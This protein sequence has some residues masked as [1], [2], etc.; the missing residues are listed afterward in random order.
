MTKPN[1]IVSGSTSSNTG[2]RNL[3]DY[4]KNLTWGAPALGDVLTGFDAVN[5]VTIHF[6]GN[7]PFPGDPAVVTGIVIA[8]PAAFPNP[9]T[10]IF[11]LNGFVTT[12]PPFG[13]QLLAQN[14]KFQIDQYQ[15]TSNPQGLDFL[16][17]Q[18]GG[19][20]AVGYSIFGGAGADNFFGS[21][22]DDTLTGNGG[23]DTLTG[24]AGDD[25]Y[26]VGDSN[27]V[28]VEQSGQGHD[29]VHA[30][31]NYTL[32]ANMEDL[33]LD[34]GALGAGNNGSNAITANDS[35]NTLTG[36]A[37]SDK[38]I[39]L[40]GNDSLDGGAGADCLDG[41]SGVDTMAGGTEN[42]TYVVDDSNDIIIEAALTKSID[43]VFS[44][45]NYTLSA[46]VENMTLT[47]GREHDIN[48]MGN[49]LANV[50][51]GNIADN[52]I[53]GLEGNDTLIGNKGHDTLIGG[54]ENDTYVV[55]DLLVK[56]VEL[57]NQGTDIVQ[58]SVN[59]TLPGNV[60]NLALT[61]LIGH[62]GGGNTQDNNITGTPGSDNIDGNIGADTMAGGA[63]DDVYRVNELGDLVVELSG[64]GEDFVFSS[65]DYT[66]PGNVD[67]LELLEGSAAL[68][69]IGNKLANTIIGNSGGKTLDGAVGADTM[70]GGDGD[71]LYFADN[72]S[73]QANEG[74]QAGGD[75]VIS[76][77]SYTLSA[78]VE[79]L[80]LTGVAGLHGGGNDLDNHITGNDGSNIINGDTGA[81]TMTGGLGGDTYIVDDVGD[82]VVEDANPG[83]DKI[84]TTKSYTLPGNVERL[85]LIGG[86]T[87]N[88]GKGN[89]DANLLVGNGFAN[90][91][92]G[93]GGADT[94]AGGGGNDFYLADTSLDIVQEGANAGT[95]AVIAAD[96]YT[97][98]GNVE[99]LALAGSAIA[100]MGNSLANIIVGNGNDNLLNGAAGIDTMAGGA[101]ND[102]YFVG[103]SADSIVE[104]L[105]GGIDLVFAGVQYALPDFVENI[106]L[107]GVANFGTL[108]NALGNVMT[109]NIGNNLLDGADGADTMTGGQGNDTYVVDDPLDKVTEG[110][111]GGTDGVKALL[112]YVLPDNV[113]NL[114]LSGINA[115]TGTGNAL[116]N[117]IAGSIADNL[118]DGLAGADSMAGL[119][120]DDTYVADDGGDLIVETANNGHD[121]VLASV[122]FS[123]PG[124]IEDL[125]LTGIGA[126]DGTGNTSNN[127]IR[128]NGAA[129]LLKGGAGNDT[130]A[131]FGGDDFLTGGTGN[132]TFVF[133]HGFKR[134]VVTD[135]KPGIDKIDLSDFHFANYAA[136]HANM[137]GDLGGV[138]INLGRVDE[139]VILGTT[140]AI[141]D[142]HAGDF[143]L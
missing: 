22:Y 70:F 19:F 2:V 32:S 77:A 64:G 13:S 119:A 101:G 69:G 116:P 115:V 134:D 10:P 92:D 52:I 30:T 40:G 83:V 59:F 97:L 136:V 37:G 5:G 9:E 62:R 74:T 139:A 11:S 108:G 99:N 96:D 122:T 6:T 88:F 53:W 143:L 27:A 42:D 133:E 128:G 126:I 28:I 112:S 54:T 38:L 104:A 68:I 103:N 33:F 90:V 47:G 3:Y 44:S 131:G 110:L 85:Y 45:A 120:G 76:S 140:I 60:E 79:D 41:G 51:M 34:A 94:M 57:F 141:L 24:H 49:D 55:D 65:I 78:N 39:G 46:N 20:F 23:A 17:V 58:S 61:G 132:D 25:L 113:E 36:L 121:L 12:F 82:L 135:Y 7:Q 21:Q 31:A 50:I 35:A 118:I 63:G 89:D 26:A 75:T 142:A 73:D 117:H 102:S 129:N 114:T 130:L 14:L 8:I 127:T 86:A 1:F 29:I 18:S 43:K 4:F 95:D 105:D 107:I 67:D 100:G 98:P 87:E 66:L 71:D 124:N 16:F 15:Q 48:G 91:L 81:D 72:S 56:V 123:L 138:T 93:S 111:N 80:L 137:I 125:T 84:L 106:T 109:G